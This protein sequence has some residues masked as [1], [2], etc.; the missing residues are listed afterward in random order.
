VSRKL[1]TVLYVGR[2]ASEKNI[3]C[4]IDAA[5]CLP[6]VT[7]C[8]AGDG[9]QRGLV[10]RAATHLSNVRYEGWVARDQVVS[11]MDASDMLVLPSKVEAFGT[12]A[13]EAMA[14]RRLVLVSPSCGILEWQTLA[15]GI[16][17]MGDG[18][19]LADAIDRIGRLR[20][21]SRGEKAETG[22]RAV[23]SL[24]EGTMAEWID[25]LNEV[26]GRT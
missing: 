11:L 12:V 6:H 8:I 23:Q 17:R 5:K 16:F 19:T 4:I 26:R 10:Q 9:P 24:N 18:E 7:F 2:L 13:L 15:G 14:R 25:V 21:E 3:D 22:Y 20:P 1:R